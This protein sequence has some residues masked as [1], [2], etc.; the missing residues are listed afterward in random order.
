MY[1]ILCC[2]ILVAFSILAA[3]I[4]RLIGE[5]Y[6]LILL[7]SVAFVGLVWRITQLRKE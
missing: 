2:L 5:P 6:V 4:D 1:E 7:I 3:S